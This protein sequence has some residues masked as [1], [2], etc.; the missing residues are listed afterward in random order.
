MKNN[1][2]DKDSA[3]TRKKGHFFGVEKK[4]VDHLKGF[5]ERWIKD[6]MQKHD[7][8]RKELNKMIKRHEEK[9]TSFSFK[10]IRKTCL[11]DAL[12]QDILTMEELLE[13]LG[14]FHDE[15]EPVAN[16]ISLLIEDGLIKKTKS[17]FQK[18]KDSRSI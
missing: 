5:R 13:K 15:A 4:E 14:C 1:T 12:D 8:T 11:L 9:H 16:T 6:Y 18:V 7:L 2:K 10:E 3:K 17:G